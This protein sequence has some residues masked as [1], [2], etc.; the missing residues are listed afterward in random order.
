MVNRNPGS[1]TRV[2]I[3]RLL[4]GARPPGYAVQ[5][6][7]HNAVAAAVR[8]G[9]ADW[10]VTLDTVARHADLGFTPLQPEQYDFVVPA[11]RAARPPVAAFVALLGQAATREALRSLG[12]RP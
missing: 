7:T 9:R 1:G 12:L 3:D 4:A 10:G 6:R 11:S 5:P 8:Q 2:L